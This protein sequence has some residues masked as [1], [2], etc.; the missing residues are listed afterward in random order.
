MPRSNKFTQRFVS[1]CHITSRCDYKSDCVCYISSLHEFVIIS[2]ILLDK[3][4]L[5]K[6]TS[7]MSNKNT[8]ECWWTYFL[9]K[10]NREL[11]I[12]CNLYRRIKHLWINP[13]SIFL[14]VPL[15]IYFWLIIKY[16]LTYTGLVLLSYCKMINIDIGIC[17]EG[18][19]IYWVI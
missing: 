1:I 13:F 6:I 7:K 17:R 14:W 3:N 5:F 16:R 4:W 11:M 9:L 15:N 19:L 2:T 12:F 18:S 8:V 10:T